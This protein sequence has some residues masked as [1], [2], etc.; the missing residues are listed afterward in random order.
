MRKNIN[1]KAVFIASI[2]ASLGT[3]LMTMVSLLVDNWDWLRQATY[4]PDGA[5]SEAV[6]SGYLRQPWNTFS[7]IL[8]IA[9]GVYVL[10]I[11]L[12]RKKASSLNIS[13]NSITRFILAFSMI[14]IGA[15]S[16][17]LHMSLSF[18]GQIADVGGMYL[19]GAFIVWYALLRHKKIKTRL[20]LLVYVASCVGLV[21][22]LIFVPNLRLYLF[23]ILIAIGLIIEFAKNK[24]VKKC[25]PD[26]LFAS[27]ST[28]LIGFCFWIIDNTQLFFEPMSPFQ[29]HALWH[30]LS[31]IS[32]LVLFF[33]YE[34][35][36]IE[37]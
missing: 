11:P 1:W 10:A 30:I 23:A 36:R 27:A 21:I 25:N 3:L 17:F 26:L 37:A 7:S 29:G 18:I 5:F 15:G 31:A 33:Y 13:E 6:R 28:L 34:P 8:M 32:M 35:E 9:F 16:T 24:K 19:L 14:V 4:M 20:F 12:L 22:F 2:A